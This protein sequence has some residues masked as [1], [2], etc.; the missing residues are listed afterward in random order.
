[1]VSNSYVGLLLIPFF[2][3]LLRVAF[4]HVV[5]NARAHVYPPMSGAQ[6]YPSGLLAQFTLLV[7]GDIPPNGVQ[8]K[9][10]ALCIYFTFLE[11]LNVELVEWK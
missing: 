3:Q 5:I 6:S 11:A 2:L 4:S 1:M 7:A 8:F 9:T 10:T